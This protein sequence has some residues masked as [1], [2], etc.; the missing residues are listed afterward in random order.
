MKTQFACSDVDFCDGLIYYDAQDGTFELTKRYFVTGNFSKYIP[1]GAKRVEVKTGDAEVLSVGFAA[2]KETVA[3][4][5]NESE[6]P[7]FFYAPADMTLYTTDK[8]KSLAESKAK[9]GEPVRLP[10]RSVTTCK[11]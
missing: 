3:I 8:E 2:E 5:A 4:L 7:K 1:Y 11:F 10:P 6:S 9:K